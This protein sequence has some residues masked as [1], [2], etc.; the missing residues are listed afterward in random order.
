MRGT[1]AAGSLIGIIVTLMMAPGVAYAPPLPRKAANAV[2][3]GVPA[4]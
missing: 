4:D 1:L 2:Q 3:Y